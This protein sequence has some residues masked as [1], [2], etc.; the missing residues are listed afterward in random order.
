MHPYI[1]SAMIIHFIR[2]HLS[3]LLL[4]FFFPTLG[5]GQQNRPNIIFLLTD[6][7][8][9][10]FMGCVDNQLI[11]TPH[12]D[13]RAGEGIL[14][15]NYH[16]TRGLVDSRINPPSGIFITGT[17]DH[18]IGRINLISVEIELPGSGNASLNKQMVE[19]Q[20]ERYPEYSFFGP[21]PAY[22]I[23]A[24]HVNTLKLAKVQFFTKEPDERQIYK[25]EDVSHLIE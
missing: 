18:P 10:D 8:P 4:A 15:T 19:E 17:P 9:Y 11:D 7:Q 23:M 22:G 1:D 5:S 16:V 20:T 13:Q 14:F 21:L 12:L 3:I 25:F 2:R 6:D 24:R